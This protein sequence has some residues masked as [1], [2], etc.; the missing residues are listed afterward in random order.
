M[1]KK[2]TSFDNPLVLALILMVL[3]ILISFIFIFL[4]FPVI[5]VPFLGLLI[6]S[7]VLNKIYSKIRDKVIEDKKRLGISFFYAFITVL[8]AF[9]YLIERMSM[10]DD[11]A[12]G[13]A[14]IGG[15]LNF[16]IV[17]FFLVIGAAIFA[18][19]TKEEIEKHK[20]EREERLKEF[21]RR[22]KELKEIE[23]KEKKIKASEKRTSSKKL[24]E[25]G[26]LNRTYI[27][28]L[29]L[30]LISLA[31]FGIVIFLDKT[32]EL[33]SVFRVKTGGVTTPIIPIALILLI[34][35]I[36]S[37]ILKKIYLAYAKKKGKLSAVNI[38]LAYAIIV[39]LILLMSAFSSIKEDILF[40]MVVNVIVFAD[41]FLLPYF[42]LR[43]VFD[44]N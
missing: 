37:L 17:Y 5:I 35:L 15:I 22:E 28:V 44:K 11:Y 3:T 42:I 32:L 4:R 29:I 21:R 23:K 25:E 13:L 34:P 12:I 43:K 41:C 14:I 27:S 39:V 19:P 10:R 38:S 8:L 24:K 2:E 20:K 9:F 40:V 30:F 31:L 18:K 33:E 36:S 1:V 7:I 26:L 16:L 6:A